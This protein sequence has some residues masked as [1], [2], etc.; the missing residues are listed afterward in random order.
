MIT[1]PANLPP[2]T[3]P[4][5]MCGASTTSPEPEPAPRSVP[6]RAVEVTDQ[7]S[8]APVAPEKKG[9]T[10]LL[11]G[12]AGLGFVGL[13]AGGFFLM[14]KFRV[15]PVQGPDTSG[16]NPPTGGEGGVAQTR[17]QKVVNLSDLEE[18]KG[19]LRGFFAAKT[20]EEKSK[21]I[22]DGASRIGDLRSFY[23]SEYYAKNT[24]EADN[25][26]A[27]P[28]DARDEE[29][30]IFLMDYHR[31]KQF[32]LA[33]FFRPIATLE[34]QM[35][36]EKP[37]LNIWT[38]ALVANFEMEG[39]RARAFFKKINGAYKLDWDSLVQTQFRLFREFGDYPNPGASGVFR[40][41]MIEDVTTTIQKD[42]DV[43]VYRVIDAGHIEDDQVTVAVEN[44]SAVG[45]LLTPFNWTDQ[46]G[47]KVEGTTATVR[48]SWTNEPE[49][50]LVIDEII[51]W[52]FL[53]IGG[54]PSNLNRYSQ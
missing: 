33:E 38:G 10:G 13:I 43:R 32:E 25:F 27:F 53:N 24:L 17:P 14:T 9:G 47:K 4:C 50:K 11:W 42:P 44:S 22:I 35:E 45:H 19:V 8:T 51:C 29:R 40:V 34:L 5:P 52:E 37:S 46:P 15:D 39:Q 2:T 6:A 41:F 3:A 31:P 21:Y 20:A 23:S 49:P 16:L 1:I 7:V 48:M 28:M 30:G 12:V 26:N 36:V 18:A 54:D